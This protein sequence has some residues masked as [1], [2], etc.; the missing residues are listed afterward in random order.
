[1]TDMENQCMNIALTSGN[2]HVSIEQEYASARIDGVFYVR[3]LQ[4]RTRIESTAGLPGYW[5]GDACI[6]MT[7]EQ[8][9]MVHEFIHGDPQ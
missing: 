7:L 6:D 9:Y 8:A 5:F 2:L 4:H 1:M 3:V